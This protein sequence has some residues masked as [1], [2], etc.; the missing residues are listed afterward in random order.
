M[1]VLI[2]TMFGAFY[3]ISFTFTECLFKRQALNY[4]DSTNLHF[5]TG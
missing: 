5:A 1:L 3:K 2:V 4:N